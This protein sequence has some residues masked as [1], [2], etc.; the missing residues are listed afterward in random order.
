MAVAHSLGRSEPRP[1]RHDVG[2]LGHGEVE[3]EQYDEAE[4][5]DALLSGPEVSGGED[6]IR[7]KLPRKAPVRRQH[8]RSSPP[9]AWSLLVAV[10]PRDAP[11][12]GVISLRPMA[13]SLGPRTRDLSTYQCT[14]KDDGPAT[15]HHSPLAGSPAIPRARR[16]RGDRERAQRP[17]ASRGTPTARRR[18]GAGDV[19]RPGKAWG[20]H[21]ADGAGSMD[22]G[23]EMPALLRPRASRRRGEGEGPA[24]RAGNRRSSKQ[25]DGPTGWSGIREGEPGPAL[26]A[27]EGPA[28]LP[29]ERRQSGG[30][31]RRKGTIRYHPGVTVEGVANVR[32]DLGSLVLRQTMEGGGDGSAAA[33]PSTPRPW[34]SSRPTSFP[35]DGHMPKTMEYEQ[36]EH[37]KGQCE[38]TL[39]EETGLRHLQG[40]LAQA[41]EGGGRRVREL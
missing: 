4:A 1:A 9:G 10:V 24:G 7:A 28:E 15:G 13:P 3:V 23:P 40:E 37:T 17:A 11:R 22:V 19:W 6:Q 38:A 2:E 26:R 35:G 14:R 5:R 25:H 21:G 36:W 39:V 16:R 12:T 8:A 30:R 41:R 27:G 34:A 20:G 32:D 31:G 18:R 33:T 29:Q